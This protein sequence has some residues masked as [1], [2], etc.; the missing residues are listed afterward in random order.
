[1]AWPTLGSRTAKEQNR[2]YKFFV[3]AAKRRCVVLLAGKVMR[4]FYF[5]VGPTTAVWQFAINE[6][7]MLCYVICRVRLSV[8]PLRAVVI[9][10]I[11]ANKSRS[12]ASWLEK[13]SGNKRTNTT[14]FTTFLFNAVGMMWYVAT[15]LCWASSIGSQHDAIRICCW[16]PVPVARR[17]QL[18]IDICSRRRRSAANPPAAVNAVD[19][20]ERQRTDGRLTVT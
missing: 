1:M 2:T 4:L 20:R 7:V 3:A 15:S 17:P 11:H 5:C 8:R 16:A 10:N 12:K 18:S 14:D 9:T 13:R 19:R 6:Y